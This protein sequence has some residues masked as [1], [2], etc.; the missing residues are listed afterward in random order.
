MSKGGCMRYRRWTR[1]HVCIDR[2]VRS[3]LAV[4]HSVFSS[5]RW[6]IQSL[7]SRCWLGNPRSTLDTND[8]NFGA[9]HRIVVL[10]HTRHP[11]DGHS[12]MVRLR[13]PSLS[14][15]CVLPILREHATRFRLDK[16]QQPI[17]L[18]LFCL[19]FTDGGGQTQ[20]KRHSKLYRFEYRN[21]LIF[22]SVRVA[23]PAALM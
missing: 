1:P 18:T 14:C 13:V 5:C 6:C 21:M 7:R 12:T 23:D 20:R 15:V 22:S 17:E 3:V 2:L 19:E 10:Y 9:I 11:L 4:R 8:P 16:S